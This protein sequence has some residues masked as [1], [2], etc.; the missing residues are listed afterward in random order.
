[1]TKRRIWFAGLLI[2]A[3]M[4]LIRADVSG[5]HQ[6]IYLFK[7]L[8]MVLLLLMVLGA[9]PLPSARYRTLI[10]TALCWSLVGDVLLMLPANLFAAGLGCFLVAHLC[11]VAAFATHGAGRAAAPAG[12]APFAFLAGV[13]LAA[14]WPVLGALRIPVALYIGV[15]STMAWQA[16]ARWHSVRSP[17]ALRAAIGSLFFLASDGVLSFNRFRGPI[18]HSETVTIIILSTY[19]AAQYLIASS[20][21]DA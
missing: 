21:G 4:A 17:G 15:I 14:L 16:W 2:L 9:T 6:Q 11:Y 3:G 18:G 12:I 7:P 10:V 1:M 13:M 19:L 5:A 8:A 20:V